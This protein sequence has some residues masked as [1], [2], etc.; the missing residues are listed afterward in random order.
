MAR[1]L[2]LAVAQPRKR[3]SRPRIRKQ[4]LPYLFILPVA[5]VLLLVNFYPMFYSLRLSLS[6]WPIDKLRDGPTLSG[7]GN[8]QRMFS[9]R[10][11]LGATGFMLFYV[12]SAVTVEFT[13]GMVVATILNSR[14]PARGVI[15]SLIILPMAVAPLVASIIW[16]Y[17]LNSDYGTV[18]YGLTLLGIKRVGWLSTLPWARISIVIVEVWQ[19][20]PFVS[21]ILLAGL[22]AVPDE[23]VEAARIDGASARQVFSRITLPL[24]RP[25]ILV[26][27][28]IRTTNAVRMFD[29]SFALTGGGPFSSTETYSLVAYTNAF[30]GFD[31]PYA[32][33]NTWLIF[34]LNVIITLV[35]VRIL[36]VKVEV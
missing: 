8:F 12:T 35:F 20:V 23:Y 18:N 10:R 34:V 32:A 11:L 21:L 9:D 25:A 1:T 5:V 4:V 36:L 33:A 30:Q 14:L 7:F 28:V 24:L 2:P 22:Q 19:Y 17:L 26:A 16:R 15:R 3:L 27:L 31:L 13:I 29:T 6:S